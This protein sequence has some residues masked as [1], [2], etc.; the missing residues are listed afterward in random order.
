MQ[1]RD[2]RFL[3]VEDHDFQRNMLVQI[4]KGLHAKSVYAAE[5]GRAG[6]DIL[7]HADA[8]PDVIIS[9]LDMPNMDGMEFIR[10]IGEVSRH[11]SLIVASAMERELLASVETMAAAYGITFLGTIEKPVTPGKL[12]HLLEKHHPP[13]KRTPKKTRP[14]LLE[15]TLDEILDGLNAG[16][17]EPFYQAKVY[18]HTREI[19]GAEG[20]A[21]W[22]HP[23]HGIVSPYAFVA[24]IEAGG[25]VEL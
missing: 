23:R 14:A 2:L 10:H 11:T 18:M 21:R 16:Q 15:F 20:L 19:A 5:D 7:E 13:P 1:P 9:D 17:F 22:R 3:V 4:L 12:E 6:L 24:A 25:H 8:Q